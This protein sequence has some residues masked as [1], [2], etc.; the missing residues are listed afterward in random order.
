[1]GYVNPRNPHFSDCAG[2]EPFFCGKAVNVLEMVRGKPRRTVDGR[3]LLSFSVPL[4]SCFFGVLLPPD[5]YKYIPLAGFE[6][7]VIELKLN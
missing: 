7:I 6:E 2:G 1:M 3:F 5:E 4:L